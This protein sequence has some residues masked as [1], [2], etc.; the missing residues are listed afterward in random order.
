MEFEILPRAAFNLDYLAVA[1][2]APFVSAGVAVALMSLAL[3]ADVFRC[4]G[5]IYYFSQRDALSALVFLRELPAGRVLGSSICLLSAVIICSWIVVRIGGRGMEFRSRAVWIALLTFMFGV[6]GVWGG[7]SSLRFGDIAATSNVCTSASLSMLKTVVKGVIRKHDGVAPV[8]ID[9]ATRRAGWLSATPASRNLV[10]VVLESG[11]APLDPRWR[12]LMDAPFADEGIRS[13]YEVETGAVPFS[14]ATVPGELRELCGLASGVMEIPPPETLRKCL[15]NRLRSQGFQNVYA[16]GF[17]SSI[18]RRDEWL[19]D[20][21][22]EQEKFHKDFREMRLR[23]CGGPFLGTCDEDVAGWIGEYLVRDPGQR[24]LVD[25]LTLNSHLP[26]SSDQDSAAILGC[27][28][29]NA[30]VSDETACNLMALVIRAERAVAKLASRPDLPETEFVIVG[31]HAPPFMQRARRE[32][33]SQS[34]VVYFHL[35]PKKVKSPK[36]Q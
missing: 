18:F 34:E 2:I 23:D 31:D 32:L 5:S 9:S 33:F 8:A 7:N 6:V 4:S 22:F 1:I 21:G 12:E 24:H 28:S 14:G 26:V 11:G 19:P 35:K 25:F 17:S 36:A 13:R 16:H 30:Q 15:P 10:L 29:E 20:V 3:L 27:G